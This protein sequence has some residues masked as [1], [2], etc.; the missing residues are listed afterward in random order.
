MF[1]APPKVKSLSKYS[2]FGSHIGEKEFLVM[3]F[4]AALLHFVFM[5]IYS[6]EPRERPMII[7][8]RVLN[9]K[10]DPGSAGLQMPKLSDMPGYVPPPPAP[11]PQMGSSFQPHMDVPVHEKSMRSATDKI[12]NNAKHKSLV[13]I[14]AQDNTG[15]TP[16]NDTGRTLR[17]ALAMKPHKYVREGQAGGVAGNGHGNG[18]NIE[19]I[20]DGLDIVRKYEQE[21]S[22]WLKKHKDYPVSAQQ[23][24]IAGNVVIRLRISREG[25]VIYSAIDVSSGNVTIDNAA[26]A[27]VRA[28]DPLPHVPDNYPEGRELEFLIPVSFE[29]N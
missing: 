9:I 17:E 28:S 27:M 5:W 15:R 8:V 25:H 6:M 7:P 26:L 4:L 1:F 21:I 19:G 11:T 13:S 12:Y 24:G 2:E 23:K 22:L 14:L 10:L 20:K 3:V 29:L 18:T 16:H